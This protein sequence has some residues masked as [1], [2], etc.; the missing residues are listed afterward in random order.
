MLMFQNSST[1]LSLSMGKL[2][3]GIMGIF[4]TSAIILWFG[5][6]GYIAND[7]YKLWKALNENSI[8]ATKPK[9]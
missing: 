9:V 1:I 5:L 3:K 8:G 7:Y 4:L 2:K 6:L